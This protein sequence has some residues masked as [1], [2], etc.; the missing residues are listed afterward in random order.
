MFQ[1]ST[2]KNKRPSTQEIRSAFT[3]VYVCS[4]NAHTRP[5]GYATLA[6]QRRRYVLI[7]YGITYPGAGGGRLQKSAEK[8]YE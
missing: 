5:F 3:W 4:E 2:N 8:F 6:E 7:F 1:S